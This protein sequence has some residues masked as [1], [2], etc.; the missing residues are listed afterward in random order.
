MRTLVAFILASALLTHLMTVSVIVVDYELRKAEI[1]EMFCINKDRPEMA[2]QGKC[3]LNRQL[4]EQTDNGPEP[5]L[6]E[7][8]PLAPAIIAARVT[9]G[10][11]DHVETEPEH[12]GRYHCPESVGHHAA[13]FHPPQRRVIC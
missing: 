5:F 6:P 3:H 2:C 13:V 4:R 9:C 12:G 8:E 11:F 7:V 1:T 10:L